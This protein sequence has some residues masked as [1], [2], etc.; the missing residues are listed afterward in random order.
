MSGEAPGSPPWT[1]TESRLLL[2]EG[3]DEV[4]FFGTLLSHLGVGGVQVLD[5]GGKDGFA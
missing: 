4:H 5:V 3:K 2:V 1:I